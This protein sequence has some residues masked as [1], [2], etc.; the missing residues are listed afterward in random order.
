MPAD[1]GNG[2]RR[3]RRK[4]PTTYRLGNRNAFFTNPYPNM[5]TI[6]A[7]VHVKL[8]Q[9]RV[10]FSWRYFDGDSPGIRELMPAFA[11]EFTLREFKVVIL[12]LGNFFGN[13]PGVLDT[14]ALA[15]AILE[16]EGWKV[17]FF[18]EDEIRRDLD[19]TIARE[20]PEL[21]NS[22]IKGPHRPNPY[23]PDLMARYR[24]NIGANRLAGSRGAMGE[25]GPPATAES[26]RVRKFRRR[27]PRRNNGRSN[28]RRTAR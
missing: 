8:E 21:I 23:S 9:L 13:I 27:Y 25:G 3:T 19:G 12:I 1:L 16:R 22:A 10:P 5:S 2:R 26:G 24:Q 4:R 28:S 20:L 14:A 6:E 15:A 17:K 11:P 18:Y 7:M